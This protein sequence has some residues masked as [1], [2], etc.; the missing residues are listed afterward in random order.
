MKQ[1]WF[2]RLRW[3]HLPICLPGALVFFAALLFCLNVVLA[4]DRRSHSVQ[5]HLVRY[6]SVFR[7]HVLAC[8]LDCTKYQPVV[9]GVLVRT[10]SVLRLD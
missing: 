5:R 10:D 8:G 4:I 6:L 2:K 3:F 9:S 1:A 7:L